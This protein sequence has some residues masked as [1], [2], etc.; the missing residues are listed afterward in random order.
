MSTRD[1]AWPAGTPCRADL[2]SPDVGAAR[3]F[4]GAVLGWSFTESGEEYGGYLMADVAGSSVAGIGPQQDG[5]PNAW[6]LYLASDDADATAA[7]VTPAGGS[8]VVPPMDVGDLGRMIIAADP[9]GGAFGVWQARRH[10]GAQRVNEPGAL[11]WEDLR[12]TD[13][14]AARAFYAGVFGFREE[15]A[16]GAPDDYRMFAL[17]GGDP[18]GGIGGM[19]DGAEGLPS[20][21][22]VYFGV[23][24]AD[25]A[26]AVAESHGGRALAPAVDTPYGRMAALSDPT[27]AVLWV[28]GVPAAA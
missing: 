9:S 27:G 10:I 16:D 15:A 18:L 1:T 4:Y 28:V 17:P 6:T 11:T 19:T 7:A 2:A 3:D 22:L 20:H 23:P 24:D 21:W 25:S 12:S 26:V 5:S 8:V 14:D 13:P